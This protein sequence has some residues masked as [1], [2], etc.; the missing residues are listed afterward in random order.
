MVLVVAYPASAAEG[1]EHIPVEDI[2][3]AAA[4]AVVVVAVENHRS[5]PVAASVAEPSAAV[6][7]ASD[8]TAA[9]VAVREMVEAEVAVLRQQ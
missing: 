5:I 9:V 2:R 7:V 4:A 1:R 3:L 6:E 8:N